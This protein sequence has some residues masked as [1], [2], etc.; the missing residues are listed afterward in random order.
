VPLDEPL[1]RQGQDGQGVPALPGGA[2]RRGRRQA[3]HQRLLDLER[4]ADSVRGARHLAD[5]V[6][7]PVRGQAV[8]PPDLQGLPRQAR[9][10][11]AAT[12]RSMVASMLSSRTVRTRRRSICPA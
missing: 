5:D 6:V 8:E 4:P 1:Q 10:K 12:S 7:E 9:G 3:I 2:F 11:P